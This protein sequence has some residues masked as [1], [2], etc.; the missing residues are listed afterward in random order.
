MRIKEY[1][2]TTRTSVNVPLLHT[3]FDVPLVGLRIKAPLFTIARQP[4]SL[5]IKNES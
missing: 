4:K 1:V 2:M 3:P 5:Q